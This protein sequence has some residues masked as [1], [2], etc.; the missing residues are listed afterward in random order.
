MKRFICTNVASIYCRFQKHQNLSDFFG[1][2]WVK[3]FRK[4]SD[5]N[6]FQPCIFEPQY[7]CSIISRNDNKENTIVRSLSGKTDSLITPHQYN[8]CRE[9]RGRATVYCPIIP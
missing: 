5:V 1:Q 6:F 3:A 7:H 2:Y 8:Y 9:P 4:S